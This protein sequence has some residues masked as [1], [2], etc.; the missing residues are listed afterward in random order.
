MDSEIRE[1]FR[2]FDKNHDNTISSNEL[3]KVLKCMGIEMPDQDIHMYMEE[4]DKEGNGRIEYREFHTFMQ[5][6]LKKVEDPEHQE[7]TVRSAFRVFDKQ[8]EGL[9]GLTELKSAMKNLGEPLTD[10][11]LDDMITMVKIN[12]EDKIDYEEFIKVWLQRNPNE[13]D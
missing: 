7:Q 11:E 2:I 9:I 1:L 4:L 3:G 12:D 10:L 6:E 13:K 5:E 8:S